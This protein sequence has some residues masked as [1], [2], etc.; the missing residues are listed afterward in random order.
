MKNDNKDN[1]DNIR[2]VL[3][4]KRAQ[5]SAGEQQ[6]KSARISA[7]VKQS[8]VFKHARNIAFYHAVR[9]EA[10]P[11]DLLSSS[12]QFFL[13]ILSPDNNQG[14]LFAPIDN[15]THYSNNE[16]SIPEPIVDAD[17]LVK[18]DALDLVIM[19]LVGFDN[20]G[21]RLGMGGGYYDRCFSFKKTQQKKPVLLGFA[22]DF[23]GIDSLIAES[24]DVGLDMIAIE[25][26]LLIVH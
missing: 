2:K 1:K 16:F 25:S 26:E 12:K 4:T 22:Y 9:G 24:W 11:A 18:G 20:Q 13:P 23:Q 8:E 19:P 15:N 14:L 21:N 5:L 10:D 17:K 6:Q 7:L 3:L